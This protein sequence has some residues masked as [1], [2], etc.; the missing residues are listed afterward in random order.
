MTMNTPAVA[1]IVAAICPTVSMAGNA[2]VSKA[3]SRLKKPAELPASGVDWTG[4]SFG[5]ELGYALDVEGT[6]SPIYGAK[7]AYDYD[8]GS[9]TIGYIFQYTRLEQDIDAGF[10]LVSY[11]R[12]GARGGIDRGLN[13]FY[14]SAGYA[15][16][17]THAAGNTNPGDGSGYFVSLGYERFIREK[18]TVGAELMYSEFS[19]FNREFRDVDLTALA[20]SVNYRF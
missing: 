20:F 10:E 3:S 15:E 9:F 8:F 16:I 17:D 12:L 7:L 4:F 18:L 11:T 5:L 13:L 19:D 2:E 14:A 1:L 6:S